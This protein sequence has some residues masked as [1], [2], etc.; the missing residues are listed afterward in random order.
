MWQETEEGVSI[1]QEFCEGALTAED[2]WNIY[3]RYN[4]TRLLIDSNLNQWYLDEQGLVYDTGEYEAEVDR[5]V[6]R[7]QDCIPEK[8]SWKMF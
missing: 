2:Y 7:G 3:E 8:I 6:K 4:V 5:W 1:L